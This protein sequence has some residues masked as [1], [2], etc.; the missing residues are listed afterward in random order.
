M[1]SQSI[2]LIA[3]SFVFGLFSL[4][5]FAQEQEE[6]NTFQQLIQEFPFSTT[7]Y[8]QEKNEIQLTGSY[9]HLE[10]DEELGNSAGFEM[11][12]GILDGF[13]VSAGYSYSHTKGEE[14]SY[15]INA[16][17]AGTMFSFF[18]NSKNSMALSLEADIPLNSLSEENEEDKPTYESTLAYGVQF[19]KTQIHLNAGAELQNEKVSWIYNIAAVYGEGNWHPMLELNS[20]DEEEFNTYLGPGVNYNNESGWELSSGIRYG[21]NNND[22]AASVKLIYEFKVGAKENS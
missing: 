5:S 19:G 10:A 1:K 18:N 3:F 22:W 21:L 14:A 4:S 7:V 13:Q 9:F 11:E 15:H 8:V 16:L 6:E 20:E 17:Q 2:S 12:Y